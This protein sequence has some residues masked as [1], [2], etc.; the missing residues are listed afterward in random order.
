MNEQMEELCK[1]HNV[2]FD[3]LIARF[4]QALRTRQDIVIQWQDCA[5][6]ATA[7]EIAGE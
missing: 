4:Q 7:L 2:N 6:I 1:Q 3:N 5:V